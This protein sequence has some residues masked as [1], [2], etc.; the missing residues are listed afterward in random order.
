MMSVLWGGLCLMVGAITLRVIVER[1]A[2]RRE[3]T[4]AGEGAEAARPRGRKGRRGKG[5]RPQAADDGRY[6]RQV[7]EELARLGEKGD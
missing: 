1:T 4:A 3:A 6:E 5:P 2:A 7:E